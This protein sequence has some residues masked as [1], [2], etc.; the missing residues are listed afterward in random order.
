MAT[1]LHADMTGLQCVVDAYVLIFTMVA[2]SMGF[3]EI[4]LVQM[5]IYL[6]AMAFFG[7]TVDPIQSE[8]PALMIDDA[9]LGF[10]PKHE[11]AKRNGEL[12][13]RYS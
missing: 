5:K 9:P 3:L 4:G 2:L 7:C 10:V 12:S 11:S 1:K 8:N 6:S 13:R